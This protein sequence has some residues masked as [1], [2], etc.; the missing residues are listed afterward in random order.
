MVFINQEF[1]CFRVSFCF[2]VEKKKKKK[3][4]K[5]LPPQLIN[6]DLILFVVHLCN[7]YY[8]EILYHNLYIQSFDRD[9]HVLEIPVLSQ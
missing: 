6:K 2:F 1:L 7:N 4:K 9:V 5:E 8:P 3:K